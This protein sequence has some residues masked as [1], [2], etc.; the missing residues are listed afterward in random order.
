MGVPCHIEQKSDSWTF[1]TLLAS[2]TADGWEPAGC[3]GALWES[4]GLHSFSSH[5]WV[6]GECVFMG[7]RLLLWLLS[8]QLQETQTY[9]CSWNEKGKAV[10]I[11]SVNAKSGVHLAVQSGMNLDNEWNGNVKR[12]KIYQLVNLNYKRFL[13]HSK[14]LW[15]SFR[16]LGWF[17]FCC[18]FFSVFVFH[19]VL[20]LYLI[21]LYFH[22]TGVR[23]VVW[24]DFSLDL[25][26]C[27]SP[28]VH[29]WN[30]SSECRAAPLPHAVGYV[31]HWFV[32]VFLFACLPPFH[33][34][35]QSTCGQ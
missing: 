21:L 26:C 18:C 27:H 2:R 16:L 12:E 5:P 4:R 33:F 8:V 35:F 19:F 22:H 14:Q 32:V 17:V 3:K 34:C 24:V 31:S 23:K 29:E 6:R 10:C 25:L 15:I 28:C 7:S 1:S 20:F 9:L 30:S 11:S 13:W